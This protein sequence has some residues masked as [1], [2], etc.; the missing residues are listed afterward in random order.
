MRSTPEHAWINWRTLPL[1]LLVYFGVYIL[2]I[3]G[4]RTPEAER[5]WAGGAAIVIAA[6][7]SAGLAVYLSRTLSQSRLQRAW[8]WLGIGFG[9][10]LLA[11]VSRLAA[12]LILGD[13]FS[14]IQIYNVI[15]VFGALPVWI[16]LILYPRNARSNTGSLA[17]LIDATII[18]TT[19]VSLVWILVLQPVLS[20]ISAEQ[21]T[22][23][24]LFPFVDIAGIGLILILFLFSNVDSLSLSFGWISLGMG[25]CM[26]SNLIYAG[27]IFAGM[28][29]TGSLMDLGWVLGDLLFALG[30]WADFRQD[31][32]RKR[33]SHPS[34]SRLRG[35]FQSI[36]PLLAVFMMGIYTLLLWTFNGQINDLA[37]YVTVVIGMGLSVRQGIYA[38]EVEMQK[39]ANLVNSIAEPA[40]VCDQ[41]GKLRLVNPAFISAAQA[42]SDREMLGKFLGDFITP[43]N[44][45]AGAVSQGLKDGWSG[46]LSLVRLHAGQIPISLTLRPLKPGQAL[47][48]TAHDL[49]EQKARQAELQSAYEQIAQ[50]RAA[51]AQ[52]NENLEQAV[53]DKTHDLTLAYHQ[54]EEQNRALQELDRLKSDFV[55]LVSHELRAPLTNINSGIELSLIT[56]PDLPPKAREN[57][58]LVQA[59]IMRLNHFIETILD[60]S[61]LDAGR[62]PLYPAPIDLN[63]TVSVLQKQMIHIQNARRIHWQIPDH[64]PNLIA[65]DRALGSILFHLLDNALKYA[66][67]GEIEVSAG[68]TGPGDRMWMRVADRGP[69]FSEKDQQRIFDRF[70]RSNGGDSQTVYGH[71]LGLYIV[72]R[73]LAAMDGDIQVLNRP[74]GGAMSEFTLPVLMEQGDGYESESIGGG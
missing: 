11:D 43:K 41:Q 51:L 25:A 65:D 71:G 10:W 62:L 40:F 27:G 53:A 44:A 21:L 23:M 67:D 24:A 4:A 73:L 70:Y 46:E 1:A 45:M 3:L 55:S 12:Y 66:P 26:V 22:A 9:V 39:F 64:L 18:A 34:V 17:I 68:L 74:D 7:L 32:D 37:L 49:S 20:V 29:P 35:V 30:A 6:V 19:M 60:L 57:L 8:L 56:N 2:W 42:E 47:A 50:D 48:G 58:N 13:H 63:N 38:G 28:P 36:L 54:L 72:K 61:A 31:S 69:G 14:S 52:L 15:Y 16:G 33:G 59:E 5:F